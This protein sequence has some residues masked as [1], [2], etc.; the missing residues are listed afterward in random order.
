MNHSAQLKVIY[1]IEGLLTLQ[2]SETL[3]E[4]KE[5]EINRLIDAKLVELAR[6]RNVALES[7]VKSE[8][9]EDVKSVEQEIADAV[10]F[11]EKEDS[12]GGT[13]DSTQDNDIEQKCDCAEEDVVSPAPASDNG[14]IEITLNDNVISSNSLRRLPLTLND[15]FRF[16]RELFGNSD[17][18]YRKAVHEIESKDSLNEVTD[19]LVDSLGFDLEN[20]EVKSFVEII[21]NVF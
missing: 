13:D 4:M 3:S 17:E 7:D 5:E 16:R 10:E 21:K 15:Q 8:Q 20:D 2:F 18:T 14:E 12:I 11:E 9:Q 1:E 19:Y 6:L